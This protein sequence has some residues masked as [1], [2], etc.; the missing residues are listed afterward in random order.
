V[1][2]N[3]SGEWALDRQASHLTGGAAAM[4]T[5]VMRINHQDPTCAFHIS[6]SAGGEAVEH[7]WESSL[8]YETP[9]GTGFYSRLFWDGDALVFACGSNSPEE[10]WSM[11]WRYELL[12][13]GQRLRAVEQMRGRGDFDN[14]WIFEKR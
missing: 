4:Q 9:I 6:M 11:V 14:T 7:T 1:K 2:P 3:F 10:T 8:S 12:V 5:G 13:A